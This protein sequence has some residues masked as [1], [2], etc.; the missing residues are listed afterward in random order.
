MMADSPKPK[1]TWRERTAALKN[2]KPLLALIWRTSPP[3]VVAM[4]ALR[5]LRSLY[6]LVSLYI[7][8]LIIDSIVNAVQHGDST[9]A[10]WEYVALECGITIVW[11]IAARLRDVVDALLGDRFANETSVRIM[12]HAASLDLVMF[13]DATFYDKLERAR[14]QTWGRVG[15]MS[16][17]LNQI[18]DVL[19]IISLAAGLMSFNPWFFVLIIIAL[20]PSVWNEIRFSGEAY[21]LAYQWTPERRKIDYYRFIGASDE[22]AKEVKIFGLA[23]FI[24]ERFRVLSVE[25][26]N[27][28]RRLAIRRAAWSTALGAISTLSY[29]SA[30]ILIIMQVLGGAISLGSLTFL[31]GSFSNV[32]GL[33]Q[34][35]FSRFS[36]IAGDALYLNDLFSFF[37]LTPQITSPATPHPFP[38][39]VREGFRF[40]GV[41]FR[42]HNSERWAV[43]NL[44]FTLG[45]GEKLALVGENGAG[46]TTLV[47]LLARLYDPTE[48][49]ILLDGI[50]LRDYDVEQLRSNIGVIFQDFVKYQMTVRE[51]IGIGR[52]DET[53]NES[54]IRH[55]AEK[56]RAAEVVE[57]LDHGYEQ[58]I[59]RRFGTGTELSGGEWQK[60]ALARAYLRSAQLLIL[61]EP[62][63]A[64][65]ARAE[66]EIFKRFT[67]LT[68][69]KSAVLISHRFSTV[70]MADRILVLDRG[71]QRELGSHEELLGK[72]G[73][74]AELFS[75]QAAG[76]K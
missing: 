53:A 27:A 26:Y 48:G 10:V 35:I 57:R 69:G 17:A 39:P 9:D 7:G 61:D 46:K 3:L 38:N 72:G 60:I 75:L 33:M 52:I 55:A 74:Y 47:K 70:R 71:E 34:S 54:A 28:N 5:L 50:D 1:P 58:M 16:D 63:A 21:S 76:Y 44:T 51:N 19:T 13:E 14:R 12:Q 59:G 23:P 73:L 40:E 30:Y 2:L 18:Q 68:A 64:L 37:E 29:Y 43:R 65:D 8:K 6:P 15:L 22:T 62:T 45:A 56:S 36:S 20:I 66:Y 67:E 31:T 25:Y 49:R 42:Y 11:A 24:I 32:Q 41:G 4:F